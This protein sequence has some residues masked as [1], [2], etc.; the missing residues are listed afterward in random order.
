MASEH[1]VIVALSSKHEHP[2]QVLEALDK[3]RSD[4]EEY[5]E[6]FENQDGEE[7]W[8]GMSAEEIRRDA[9]LWLE[10]YDSP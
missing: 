7:C 1:A 9:A 10:S 5:I 4:L 2:K 8:D 3:L 6:E